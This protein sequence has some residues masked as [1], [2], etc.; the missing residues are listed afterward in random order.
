MIWQRL[1]KCPMS[2]PFLILEKWA[3]L[4]LPLNVQKPI[5][6]QLQRGY[7]PWPPD[8]GLQCPWTPLGALQTDRPVIG[9]RYRARHGA[10]S[11][12]Y[13]RLEPPLE[14]K[15]APFSMTDQDAMPSPRN[16][17][18][19]QSQKTQG[20]PKVA[21]TTKHRLTTEILNTQLAVKTCLYSVF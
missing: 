13:Y 2:L 5:V 12:R 3:N 16:W 9:S 6:L 10:V 11:S 7:V 17:D 14:A 21:S 15:Q 1:N 18:Q 20:H 8:Q 4:R 19:G